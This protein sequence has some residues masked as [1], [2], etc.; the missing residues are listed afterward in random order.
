MD[1]AGLCH[2]MNEP[3]LVFLE[4]LVFFG[5]YTSIGELL[6]IPIGNYKI[7][8]SPLLLARK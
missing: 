3:L 4:H 2:V 7:S 1:P 8:L 5:R 6:S